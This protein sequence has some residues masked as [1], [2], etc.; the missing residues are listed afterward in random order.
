MVQRVSEDDIKVVGFKMM[1]K[2]GLGEVDINELATI[3][4]S[5]YRAADAFTFD[6]DKKNASDIFTTITQMFYTKAKEK[7]PNI[8]KVKM[9]DI[10]KTT[11]K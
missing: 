7:F 1:D 5:M 3:L 2:F 6:Y 9:L 8:Q 10:P 4:G 11:T